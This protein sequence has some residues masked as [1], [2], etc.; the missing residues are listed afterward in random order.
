M[1]SNNQM[2]PGG[3]ACASCS[4]LTPRREFV[5]SLTMS[6]VGALVALGASPA[7]AR[8]M[9]M[10][11][12]ESGESNSS[13]ASYPVPDADCVTIDRENAVILARFKG[14]IYAFALSCPHQN[15]ALKW[16]GS[17]G[18]FQCPKHRSRYQPDGTFIE[19]RATRGMDRYAIQRDGAKIVV[20]LN[21]MFEQDK[22]AA[23]WNAAR[24]TVA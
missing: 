22:D 21:T 2:P 20:D 1:S 19:G 14:S 3:D 17:D 4:A 7:T 10:R 23:G 5:R 6:A 13:Q 12:D 24:V 9:E 11:F 16:L 15:T 18:L 8:A